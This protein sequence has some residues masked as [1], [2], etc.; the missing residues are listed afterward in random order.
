[1]TV[2]PIKLKTS[3]LRAA[4]FKDDYGSVALVNLKIDGY[5]AKAIAYNSQLAF[6]A[7]YLSDRS[8]QYAVDDV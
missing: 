4:F 1:M 3:R 5:C 2:R 7:G 6:E 8:V